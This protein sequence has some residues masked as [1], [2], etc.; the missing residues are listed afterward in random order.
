MSCPNYK[1]LCDR[2]VISEAVT[3]TGGNLVIN[4]P[5]GAYANGEKYCIIVAQT[6]PVETTIAAPV[7]ITIGDD[8]TTTYPLTNCDCSTVY[9]CSINTRTRYSVCVRTDETSGVFKLL[10]KLP[11]S[12]CSN[13][14]VSLPAPATAATPVAPAI[15][16]VRNLITRGV[17]SNA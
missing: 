14:L 11:C 12:R 5:E 1:R 7:V 3:F 17:D 9:A 10:G 8:A 6:I 2:L 4:L 13:N 16:E 15:A